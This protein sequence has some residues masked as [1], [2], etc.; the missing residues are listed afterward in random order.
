[1]VAEASGRRQIHLVAVAGDTVR[2]LTSAAQG[3]GGS[4]A[5]SPDG[6]SIAF[7]AG[8]AVKRNP[9]LPYRLDRVTY[10]L[11]GLGYVDYVIQNLYVADVATGKARQLT[12][13]RT[14][15][16]NPRWSPDGR[17]LAYL[18]SFRPDR[19]WN[20][21]AELHVMTVAEGKSR[22]VVDSWGGVFG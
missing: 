2:A 18:V 20:F 1:V 21:L 7:T 13:D 19:E 12:N 16:G 22:P 10:R 8:P 5:W 3:V 6:R 17:S 14:M 4:L 9:S 15:K 11:D